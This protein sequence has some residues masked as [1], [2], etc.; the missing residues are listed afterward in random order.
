MKKKVAD[1]Y[2]S[3]EE[4]T[5]SALLVLRDIIKNCDTENITHQL[6]YGMPFFSFKG[7]MFCYL[8]TDKKTD[9]PYIGFVEGNRMGYPELE[10]GNRSRMKIFRINPN[11]D[12]PIKRIELIIN[13]A[14]DFYRNGIIK[15]NS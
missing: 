12:I 9:E 5:K 6:K 15:I 4:P 8:W 7:K 11:V 14:L 2:L 10:Q 3:K 1:F 13:E